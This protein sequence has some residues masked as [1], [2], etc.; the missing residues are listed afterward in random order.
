MPRRHEGWRETFR[1]VLQPKLL[2]A[3]RD[4]RAG[5]IPLPALQRRACKQML[6]NTMSQAEIRAALVGVRSRKKI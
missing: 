1:K 2:K 6:C 3:L 5:R 4:D